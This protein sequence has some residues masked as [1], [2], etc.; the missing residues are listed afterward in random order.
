MKTDTSGTSGVRG[1]SG[2]SGTSCLSQAESVILRRGAPTGRG[3][4][5]A[6]QVGCPLHMSPVILPCEASCL[7][8]IYVAHEPQVDPF[9]IGRAFVLDEKPGG[10][11]S[12]VGA[13]KIQWM[14]TSKP[15]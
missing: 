8:T 12:P 1:T 5:W 3:E 10:R 6:H 9:S 13:L 11:I 14:R 4:Q 15:E 2:I 7:P